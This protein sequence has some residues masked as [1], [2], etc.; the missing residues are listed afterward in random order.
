MYADRPSPLPED[1]RIP[2]QYIVEFA[3]DVDLATAAAAVSER[4]GIAIEV[5]ASSVLPFGF[6]T[7]ATEEQAEQLQACPEVRSIEPN[8]WV[9]PQGGGPTPC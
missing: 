1:N 5:N 3:E 4:V 9:S 7:A 8:R 2:G 6:V